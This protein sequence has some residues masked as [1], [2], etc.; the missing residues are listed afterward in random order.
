MKVYEKAGRGSYITVG[1]SLETMALS[2]N[3][4]ISLKGISLKKEFVFVYEQQFLAQL[5]AIIDFHLAYKNWSWI[6]ASD[7]WSQRYL[8][9]ELRTG[10]AYMFP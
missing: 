3:S 8:G 5:A 2:F 1:A 4:N 7:Q 10:M 9:Y 6:E